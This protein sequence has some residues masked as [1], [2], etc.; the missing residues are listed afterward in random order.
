MACQHEHR[1]VVRR[2]VA[3][4]TLPFLV[5]PRPPDTGPPRR[6]RA[7]CQGS[8]TALRRTRRPR[9]RSYGRAVWAWQPTLTLRKP[10]ARGA[11]VGMPLRYV[12]RLSAHPYADA[13]L[14]RTAGIAS[15]RVGSRPRYRPGAGAIAH[16]FS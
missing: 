10:R 7:G 13:H 9:S 11:V 14:E 6:R 16:G 12:G 3:P 5:G 2:V 1:V 15:R 8:A 4:P